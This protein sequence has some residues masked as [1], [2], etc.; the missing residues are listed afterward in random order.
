M[1][2]TSR[3]STSSRYSSSGASS[4]MEAIAFSAG[5]VR[6]RYRIFTSTV[7]AITLCAA[8]YVITATPEYTATALLIIDAQKPRLSERERPANDAPIDSLAIDSQIEIL[9]SDNLALTVVRKFDLV[10]AAEFRTGSQIAAREA[11][12]DGSRPPNAHSDL[13]ERLAVASLR[14]RLDVRRVGNTY[15]IQISFRAASPDLAAL[16]ANGLAEGYIRD[17]LDTK[18]EAAKTASSWLQDRIKSLR[19]QTTLADQAVVDFKKTNGLIN[20]GGVE[21]R[22]VGDQQVA[23]LNSQL[24]VAKSATSEAK[25][26]LDRIEDV[27]RSGNVNATVTDALKSDVV[28]KLRAQYFELAFR[29][30]DWSKRYGRD[31]QAAVQL[32]SQISEISRA[33]FEEVS[34]IGETYKSDYEISKQREDRVKGDLALA[35]SNSQTS[36]QAEVGLNQLESDALSY[37]T[38]FN[39]FL[40]HYQE[41][42]QQQS[43]PITEARLI[44]TASPPLKKSS[45]RSLYILGISLAASSLLGFGLSWLRDRSDMVFRTREDVSDSLGYDFLGFI[46]I[47]ELI[48]RTSRQR[49]DWA[50]NFGFRRR[51]AGGSSDAAIQSVPSSSKMMSL[52]DATVIRAVME[53]PLSP[54]T[55]SLRSLKLSIDASRAA[56]QPSVVVGFTSSLPGEGKSTVAA[57]VAQV[58][59]QSGSRCI[60]VDCDLR[61]PS[62]SRLLA[63][64]AAS[65]LIEVLDGQCDLDDV[66]LKHP[67]V[68]LDFLPTVSTSAP[69]RTSSILASQSALN[70]FGW[71]RNRYDYIIVDCSPVAPIVDVRATTHLFDKYIYVVE[72]GKTSISIVEHALQSAPELQEHLVGVILNKVEY[73]TLQ[74]YGSHYQEYYT[75][76]SFERYG[77]HPSS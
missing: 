4:P 2:Q 39:T 6:R 18:Y 34:R 36:S 22:L 71:L 27:L 37:R 24:V 66:I 31:H 60:L 55:E 72:W 63:P 16:I 23:E 70:L 28:T 42:I 77:M 9:R 19:D 53:R 74:Q 29:E 15:V 17:Q 45:P 48:G 8:L 58:I 7:L 46:P 44:S 62:L 54:F 50:K 61:N 21:K 57:G 12:T 73:E 30:A 51:L 11:V 41:L 10:Q 69:L 13:A 35:V 5:L 43:F 38:L 3:P 33:I 68:A 49:R 56:G 1:L 25:A 14:E 67:S 59:A 40:Q 26:R 52:K 76:D 64:N 65:G 75:S 47:Q 32:R 20:T